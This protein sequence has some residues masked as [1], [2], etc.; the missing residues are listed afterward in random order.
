MDDSFLKSRISPETLASF[1]CNRR[2]YGG[3]A[4]S[5][6]H[7]YYDLVIPF[8]HHPG[9]ACWLVLLNVVYD[10]FNTEKYFIPI[11]A[12]NFNANIPAVHKIADI[13][14]WQFFDAVYDEEFR[15]KI[16]EAIATESGSVLGISVEKNKKD[17]KFDQY[18]S[19][20]VFE[21]E[22]SNSSFIVNNNVFVK[23]FRKVSTEENP[24]YEIL[25][26]FAEKT[27]FD[28]IPKYYGALKL[29]KDKI[30]DGPTGS[31]VQNS[32]ILVALAI[33]KLNTNGNAWQLFRT[34]AE[35]YLNFALNEN[36]NNVTVPELEEIANNI[37]WKRLGLDFRHKVSL[38]G[39]I[40]A[41]MHKSLAINPAA[42][43]EFLK[44]L[45]EDNR[46]LFSEDFD[47]LVN[48][49]TELLKRNLSHFEDNDRTKA[50]AIIQKQDE[51]ITVM[52]KILSV[53]SSIKCI[54]IHGDYHLGQILITDHD[55]VIIDF[56][57]EPDK[58]HIYRRSK[59]PVYKDLAG[60]IRSFHYSVYSCL[61][62]KNQS[63]P[64]IKN[65][66]EP[67]AKY[68]YKFVKDEFLRS[69]MYELS[70]SELIG[71][72]HFD[73]ILSFFM[74]EKAFYELGYE[75]NN[76]PDWAAIPISGIYEQLSKQFR[77]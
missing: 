42:Q 23:I 53:S 74:F 15:K 66:L 22:Q 6:K 38:L 31:F 51:L 67:I 20:S 4:Q 60:M 58:P 36:L 75:L 43:P 1:L 5:I 57:G 47:K 65:I 14:G 29:F 25:R 33:E 34:Y 28:K 59:F 76:R 52:Q 13:D 72:A 30:Y 64:G 68:W 40:T 3:K 24:D 49:T 26:Y 41:E 10:E 21:T 61:I 71:N 55:F 17:F 44:E 50:N 37:L 9:Q 54:R 39:K 19:S 2:W 70:G 35:N 8:Y 77:I 48:R 27:G 16:T 11:S 7:S 62:E 73:E 46:K 45:W 56:E 63:S 32:S 69:Y 12:F 18:Q